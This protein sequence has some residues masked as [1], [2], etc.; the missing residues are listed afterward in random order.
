VSLCARV[1]GISAPLVLLYA[2]VGL[3]WAVFI[4]LC[5]QLAGRVG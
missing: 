4:S 1:V 5:N 2:A 3:Y